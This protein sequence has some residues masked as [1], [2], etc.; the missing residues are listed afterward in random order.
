MWGTIIVL[1][2]FQFEAF[3]EADQFLPTVVVFG[4]YGMCSVALTYI[5][6]FSFKEANPALMFCVSTYAFFGIV[7]FLVSWFMQQVNSTQVH[8]TPHSDLL[9]VC[10]VLVLYIHI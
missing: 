2:I 7:L 5:C 10:R 3:Y 1:C 6:S 4:T 9:V 8:L